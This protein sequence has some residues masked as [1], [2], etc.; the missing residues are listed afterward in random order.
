M[1]I[2]SNFAKDIRSVKKESGA[3]EW[4]YFDA[5]SDDDSVEI[6]VIFYEGN[7]F[8]RRYIQHQQNGASATPS[9]FPAISISIYK[10]HEPIYYSFTEVPKSEASFE[11]EHPGV[12]IA[13]HEMNG[14]KHDGQTIYTLRLKE[15]LPSGDAIVGNLTFTSPV[16]SEK[17]VLVKNN[18]QQNHTWN[19]VQPRARV[20]GKIRCFSR[21]ESPVKIDFRGN[22]YHDHNIGREP[23]KNEFDDWYWGRFHF[24]RTNLVYY[25]M[26]DNSQKHYGWLISRDNKEIVETFN[27]IQLEDF[28]RSLYGLSTSRRITLSNERAHVMVQQV[29]R[30][31]NGPFYQ[32]YSSD[33]FLNIPEY[34]IVQ[35]SRGVTEY[36]CPPRIY[37]KMYWPLTN[38]RIN[39]KAEGAHW[40]QRSKLLYRWTW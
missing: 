8:S 31:D 36:L 27:D 37:K 5:V 28:S 40:V 22:G 14:S 3:Y 12:C 21:N 26:G 32:R 11:R 9:N 25:V 19:L 35:S 33:A 20:T 15:E 1:K 18:D 4:W 38:M 23:L 34:N 7:P 29:H 39:Y 30:L 13:D 6:V 24:E 10:D 17:L 2:T 16:V